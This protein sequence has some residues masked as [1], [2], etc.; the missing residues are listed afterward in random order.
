MSSLS[1]PP[2]RTAEMDACLAACST[3]H[4]TC[5]E[6]FSHCLAMG[7][8][9]ADRAHITLLIACA[10]ICR[11]SADN[12]LRRTPVHVDTCEACAKICRQCATS[13]LAMGD[14]AEMKRCADAC[15]DCADKCDAMVAGDPARAMAA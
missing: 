9:H 6:T 1:S 11:A 15:N 3:C 13:C 4:D 8:N 14:D 7:G 12:L 5:L 2:R 10:D